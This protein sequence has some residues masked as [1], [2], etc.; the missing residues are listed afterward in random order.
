MTSKGVTALYA[1]AL[2]TGALL[3]FSVQPLVGRLIQPSLGGSPAAWT[4][5]MLFFQ[6]LVVA[7]Y[8][9]A[10]LSTRYLAPRAQA[11]VHLA[12]AG[13]G[14][15]FLPLS[16]EATSAISDSATPALQLIATLTRFMGWPMLIVA[17]TAPLLQYWFSRLKHEEAADPYFLYAAS[18]AGSL[19]ALLAYPLFIDPQWGLGHQSQLWLAGYLLLIALLAI[20]AA[21]LWMLPGDQRLLEPSPPSH[22]T[23]W[24]RRL[25]WLALAFVPSTLFLSVTEVIT[26]DIAPSPVLWIPPLA[27]YTASFIVAFSRRV[28]ALSRW[29]LHLSPLAILIATA[30]WLLE[31]TDPRGLVI[32]LHLV[33]LSILALAFHGLLAAD[34]PHRQRLTDFYIWLAVGATLGG[35]FNALVAPLLFNGLWEYLI[36]LAVAAASLPRSLLSA[37]I[38][39]RLTLV[40]GVAVTLWVAI[41]AWPLPMAPGS[42][43]IA[44][45]LVIMAL[46]AALWLWRRP[47]KAPIVLAL[48]VGIALIWSAPADDD[49]LHRDRSFFGVHE[50]VADRALGVHLLY[51]GATVHGAQIQGDDVEELPLTYYGEVGPLGQLF[52]GLQQ[53]DQ[54]GPIAGVGLGIGTLASYRSSGQSLDFIDIDPT[55]IDIAS[56]PLWFTHLSRCGD[57]CR[58]IRGD[59]RLRLQEAPKQHYEAIILDA[60]SSAAVPTHLLTREALAT[61]MRALKPDG[62]LAIHISSPYLDLEP[63]LTSTAADLGLSTLYQSHRVERD[64]PLYDIYV[65]SS[66]WLLVARSDD[67]LAPWLSDPRWEALNPDP[68]VDPWS[69]DHINLMDARR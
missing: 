16:W 34:R 46:G 49:V 19:V 20:T 12:V 23:D 2:A 67:V 51:H 31:L 9:Y 47:R 53:R 28:S 29:A 25:R 58:V 4:T 8:I 17:A 30:L 27:I 57:S 44:G 64:D 1:L 68:K 37:V 50:V 36:G 65:E 39:R 6:G 45:T 22:S 55:V 41:E 21:A 18:N 66:A 43:L 62:I 26:T 13:L 15:L 42:S 40:A 35:L 52:D 14:L 56:E 59:G 32:A 63:P 33:V 11:L 48:G 54:R 3:L 61:Y 5:V 10:H 24:W 38:T 7:G 60:Y 69:D